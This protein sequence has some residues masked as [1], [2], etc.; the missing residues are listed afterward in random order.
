MH[1]LEYGVQKRCSAG[2][3]GGIEGVRAKLNAG[4]IVGCCVAE[5]MMA[6]YG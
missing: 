3:V 5:S 4:G 6:G 1:C 2:H